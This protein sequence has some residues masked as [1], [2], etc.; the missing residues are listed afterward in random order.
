MKRW[1]GNMNGKLEA[2]VC[3]ATQ[4]RAAELVKSS[5]YDFRNYY[6]REDRFEFATVT[7]EV[8]GVWVRPYAGPLRVHTEGWTQKEVK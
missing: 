2:L 6:R 4:K 1:V 7:G 3:A 8:E 5:L